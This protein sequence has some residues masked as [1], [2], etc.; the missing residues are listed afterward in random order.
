V[1]YDFLESS[2]VRY[3]LLTPP[4]PSVQPPLVV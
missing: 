3:D 2:F 1:S 4:S